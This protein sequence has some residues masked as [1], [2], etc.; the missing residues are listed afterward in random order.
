MT[1]VRKK[2]RMKLTQLISR[3]PPSLFLAA[4]IMQGM[5]LTL[6][7]QSRSLLREQCTQRGYYMQRKYWMPRDNGSRRDVGNEC[8]PPSYGDWWRSRCIAYYRRHNSWPGRPAQ[9]WPIVG[10][11]SCMLW[12]RKQLTMAML[13]H[14]LW[15][16]LGCRFRVNCPLSCN[17]LSVS[18]SKL[19]RQYVA[20]E[21]C[22]VSN[23]R[24][25]VQYGMA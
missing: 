18:H 3:S 8:C 1:V 7:L 24:A 22:C 17:W 20:E 6:E 16:N 19:L 2:M 9:W 14:S 12:A 4:R 5:R 11:P 23:S 10:L 13:L 15:C 21:V 25:C